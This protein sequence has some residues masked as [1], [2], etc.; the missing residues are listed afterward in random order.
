MYVPQQLVPPP[1]GGAP[2]RFGTSGIGYS[3]TVYNSKIGVCNKIMFLEQVV[4]IVTTTLGKGGDISYRGS[5]TL[6]NMV[7]TFSENTEVG[8]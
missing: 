1:R 7:Q 8:S 2:H 6:W 4:Q 3:I 5:H